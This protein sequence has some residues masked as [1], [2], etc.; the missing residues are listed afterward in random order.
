MSTKNLSIENFEFA[1][2]FDLPAIIVNNNGKI[3]SSNK[4]F[5][6]LSGL[7]L[8]LIK[9]QKLDKFIPDFKI[10]SNSK[11]LAKKSKVFNNLNFITKSKIFPVNVNIKKLAS[12]KGLYSLT[13]YENTKDPESGMKPHFEDLLESV[14]AVVWKADV[15]TFRI[16]YISKEAES[17]LGFPVERWINEET[18]WKDHIYGPDREWAVDY[19]I[20]ETKAHRPHEF[21]YRMITSDGRIIWVRDTVKLIFRNGKPEEMIGV[22]VDITKEKKIIEDFASNKFLLEEAQRLAHIGSF[23]WDI[24]S[25]KVKW[26]DEMFKIYGL[27]AQTFDVTYESFLGQIHPADKDKTR[28]VIETAVKDAKPFISEERIL[29]PTGEIR[30]L[31][32]KGKFI[33]EKGNAVKLI[34]VCKDITD[35]IKAESVLRRKTSFIDLLKNIAVAA[36]E[37]KTVEDAIN[38]CINEI[39]LKTGWQLGHAYIVSPDPKSLLLPTK[40]WYMAEGKK[41][42][43]FKLKTESSKFKVREGLPGRVLNSKKPEW[44]VNL[45]RDNN[46][47]RKEAARKCGLKSAFA[48]PVF[49]ENKV[50]GVLEFFSENEQKPDEKLYDVIPNISTQIGR[51]IERKKADEKFKD[52]LESAPDAMVIV[53]ID[54]KIQMVNVQTEKIFGFKRNEIIGKG[55]EVLI[56]ERFQGIHPEHRKVFFADPRVRGMG[57]GL[58]LYGKRKDGTEFPVEISLSPLDTPEGTLSLAAIRDISERKKSEEIVI[59]NEEKFRALAETANDGIVS[60]DTNNKIIYFNIGAEKIFGYRKEEVLNRDLKILI[61]KKYHK[62]YLKEYLKTGKRKAI[63]Q[64]ID[65]EGL[66][67]TGEIIPIEMS[68][69]SWKTTEGVFFTT[70]IRDITERK[71]FVN[72]LR[73]RAKQ[74]SAI[75]ELGQIAIASNNIDFII[76]KAL[77]A[78]SKTLEV[79]FVNIFELLKEENSLLLKAGIGWEKG[80]VGNAKVS[81]GL[82]SLCGYTL[83]K[84]NEVIVKD[85]RK[86]RRFSGSAMLFDHDVVS[87]MCVPI[88]GF[89]SFYGVIG[90]YSK[91][92]KNFDGEDIKFMRAIANIVAT[93]I[94]KI[95]AAEELNI[96]YE[97]LKSTQR[98]LIHSEKLAALGRFSSGIAHEIRNPLANIHAS[99]QFA[100]LKFDVDKKMK[101]HLKIMLRNT[102]TANRIIKELLDFASPRRVHLS[103]ENIENVINI[104]CELV[105]SRCRNH[106]IK[107]IKK[108]KKKLPLT[109]I[110]KEKLEEAFLNFISN[111]ID[112]MPG[113]GKLV[114][115]A[116]RKD[117]NIVISFEDTGEGIHP[118]LMDN[119]MEPFFTTKRKGTGLGL[120][121]AHQIIKSHNGN[122]AISS[123]VGSGTTIEITF[124]VN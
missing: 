110:N 47:F 39:C 108:I 89:S 69:A 120:S 6:K 86:E 18:F 14:K 75:A 114:V 60:S 84:E 8:G 73:N 100:L 85:L 101:K 49:A 81:A 25:N 59:H 56:P 118:D 23:E 2:V 44:I 15:Q 37:A 122:L 79:E 115:S 57:I 32:T 93:A 74:Q 112:A 91:K 26:S 51:V 7:K 99:A 123:K 83:Y 105:N 78:V 98:E 28:K 35:Q 109:N 10:I 43:Q 117:K 82:K 38:F 22:I 87:G 61:P 36:N 92:Q 65:L 80:L 76:S 3:V 42:K 30:Y 5:Q 1:E 72:S 124:P 40:L 96:T 31:Q 9:N 17:L 52:L 19:C 90:A 113:G 70:M 33:H 21:E 68:L 104:V 20:N 67:K 34:G 71:K 58:E 119:I 111:S 116:Y 50:T 27:N 77:K 24:F 16:T 53:G 54:G 46:F 95:H 97:K 66:H 45:S 63:R 88:P 4:K 107:L 11:G 55:V 62:T 106:N 41:Y 13:L 121:L 94:N 12:L 48:F 102:E 29:R 64:T 103:E